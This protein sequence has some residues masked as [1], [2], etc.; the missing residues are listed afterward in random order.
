MSQAKK[1]IHTCIYMYS[2]TSLVDALAIR[3]PF[4]LGYYMLLRIYLSLYLT[5]SLLPA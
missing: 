1:D 3:E 4:V 5:L 2:K